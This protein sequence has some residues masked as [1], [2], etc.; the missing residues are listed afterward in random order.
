MNRH[1]TQKLIAFIPTL[2]G[3]SLLVFG[4]MRLIPG[5]QITATLGTEAG[6]LS[7]A[8]RE[9]LRSYYGLDKTVPE[10]YVNWLV[11][12]VQGDLGFSIRHGRSVTDLIV[13]HFPLTFQLAMM[14]LTIAL[15]VGVPLGLLAAVRHNTPLDFVV[16]IVAIA[17]LSM[18]NFL[19][20]TLII[21]VLSVHFGVLPTAGNYVSLVDDPLRNLS[22]LIFPALTLG[23]AFAA[24]L[25]RT[26]R[27][28][29]LESLS[30]DYIRTARSKGLRERT[31]IRRHALRNSLIPVITLVG[32]QMGYLFGGTFIVEQIFALPGIGR[33]LVNAISQREYALVQ[34]VTLFIAL[35]FLLINFV[36]DLIYSV[37]DPRISYGSK[38]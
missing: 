1:L 24:S 31:V 26:T 15:I 36:V 17:G 2:F 13:A 28:I 11:R 37:V 19:I 8:Q 10:Q 27:S 21:Y 33:L 25:M 23:F 7:E 32:V 16:Q 4:A 22:Q 29:M 14:S 38:H 34:G 9:A 6:M 35:S 30:Q 18:P 3:V 12:A 5:D 20:G